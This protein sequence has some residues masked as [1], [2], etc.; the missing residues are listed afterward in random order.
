MRLIRVPVVS[1]VWFNAVNCVKSVKENRFP[2]NRLAMSGLQSGAAAS[3][4][5]ERESSRYL[6]IE[7]KSSASVIFPA[8]S[9]SEKTDKAEAGMAFDNCSDCRADKEAV[10]PATRERMA[11][12]DGW[13]PEIDLL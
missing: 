12:A 8:E 10:F 5:T 6:N 1:F 7:E 13:M 11:V 4:S 2:F 9:A 3:S